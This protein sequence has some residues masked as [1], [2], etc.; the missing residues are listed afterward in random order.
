ML[1]DWV[2]VPPDDKNVCRIQNLNTGK[3][4]AGMTDRM[5]L[6]KLDED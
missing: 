6:I 4:R 5:I 1:N 2:T 3:R